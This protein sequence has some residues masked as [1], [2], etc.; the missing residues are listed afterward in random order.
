MKQNMAK[1]FSKVLEEAQQNWM[2]IEGVVAVAK[3]KKDQDDC[4]DVYIANNTSQ[5]KKRIPSEYKGFPVVYRESGGPF[6]PQN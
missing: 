6:E 5:I 3:G 4:I 1:D 2:N